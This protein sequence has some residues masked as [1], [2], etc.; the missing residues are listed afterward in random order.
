MFELGQDAASPAVGAGRVWRHLLA[1]VTDAINR[2]DLVGDPLTVAHLFWSAIHG[3]IALHLAGKLVIGRTLDDLIEP[4][5]HA[6]WRGHA[7]PGT[8]PGPPRPATP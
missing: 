7:P 8:S 5:L 6:A 2:G 1:A 4:A 3:L